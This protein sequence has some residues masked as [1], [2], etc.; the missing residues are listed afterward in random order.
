MSQNE[1]LIFDDSVGSRD[2][3]CNDLLSIKSA[4]K[5][6]DIATVD[7]DEFK[8]FLAVL[9]ERRRLARKEKAVFKPNRLDKTA[10]LVLDYDLIDLDTVTSLTAEH[11]AYLVRC[12]STCGVI[13]IVNQLVNQF[14]GNYF[15]LSL[16]GRLESFGDLNVPACQLA[17]GG[18]WEE[19]LTGFRPWLWPILPD[20]ATAFKRR[21]SEL[22]GHLDDSILDFLGISHDVAQIMPRSIREFLTKGDHPETTTFREFVT[23]SGSGL[24]PK[25]RPIDDRFV[26]GIAAARIALWLENLV[27]P[28]QDILVDAPHLVSRFPSLLSAKPQN[29]TSWRKTCSLGSENT[30]GIRHGQISPFKFAPRNWLSRPAWFWRELS[31]CEDIQEVKEPWSTERP[32]HVFC[33][34][35]SAFL[36]REATREFVADLQSQFARRFV[37][38]PNSKKA[39]RLAESVSGVNYRPSVRLS[40]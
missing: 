30:L 19:P 23:E 18:L 17:S 6:F 8:D 24:T 35:V 26:A 32:G 16:K 33:E 3:W 13:V 40:M 5:N 20:A 10:I 31:N 27:L 36:P 1:I 28:G 37:V 39:G 14:G 2:K 15:D 11:V 29:V 34:D 4:R 7:D 38:D 22:K 21:V 9:E 25:D 12:Y